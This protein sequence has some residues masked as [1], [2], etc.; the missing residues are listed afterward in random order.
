[1]QA[2]LIGKKK[3]RWDTAKPNVFVMMVVGFSSRLYRCETGVE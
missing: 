1:V 3:V 2:A